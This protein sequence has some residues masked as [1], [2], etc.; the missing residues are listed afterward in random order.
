MIRSFNIKDKYGEIFDEL[1]N[2]SKIINEMISF[3]FENITEEDKEMLILSSH[4]QQK[5]HAILENMLMRGLKQPQLEQKQERV[6]QERV[7]KKKQD[8]SSWW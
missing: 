8:Y 4:S 3:F 7:E 6:K 2:K 1:P 5:L